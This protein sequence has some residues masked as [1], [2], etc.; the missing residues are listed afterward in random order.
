MIF[1]G[2]IYLPEDFKDFKEFIIRKLYKLA[3]SMNDKRFIMDMEMSSGYYLA[4]Y[5]EGYEVCAESCRNM[6]LE[7]LEEVKKKEE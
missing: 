2:G 6:V 5:N 7:L 1:K 3:V 4:G